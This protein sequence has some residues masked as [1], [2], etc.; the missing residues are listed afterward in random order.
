MGPFVD[1]SYVRRG[2]R[3]VNT[4]VCVFNE[5]AVMKIHFDMETNS[6][7]YIIKKHLNVMDYTVLY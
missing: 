2:R 1:V 7:C 3:H 6:T 5:N 4:F